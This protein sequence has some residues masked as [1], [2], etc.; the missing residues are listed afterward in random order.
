[1]PTH[2]AFLRG[3]N[4]GPHRKVSSAELRAT[5]ED[6]GFSDVAP[7]RTSGNVALGAGR[8]SDAK[9]SKRI[10]GALAEA[11]GFDVTVFV[12]TAGEVLA[13]A[14]L[15]PFPK[16]VIDATEGRLQVIMLSRKPTAAARKEVLATATDADRLVLAG[17]ELYWLPTAGT[18]TAEW[19]VKTAD[20][21]LGETTMRTM[22]TI[23]ALA[24]KYF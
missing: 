16:K 20:E 17:R 7:F 8:E 12:R 19:S 2:A 3:V 21:L 24:A 18:Q 4:L 23:E 14:K 1:M 11:L 9:L 5:F 13:I 22:G 6:A 15:N 10:E